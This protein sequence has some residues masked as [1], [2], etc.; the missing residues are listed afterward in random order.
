MQIQQDPIMTICFR[1]YEKLVKTTFRCIFAL[2]PQEE[3]PEKFGKKLTDFGQIFRT[4]SPE[5]EKILICDH[6]GQLSELHFDLSCTITPEISFIY[7]QSFSLWP[8]P[9]IEFKKGQNQF[10]NRSPKNLVYKTLFIKELTHTL[11]ISKHDVIGIHEKKK[12]F[13]FIPSHFC[14][15]LESLRDYNTAFTL[16]AASLMLGV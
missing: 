9:F 11:F 2:P 8:S 16:L 1:V 3:G 7:D 6:Y 5:L 13:P 4:F 15:L 12:I 10:Y 14:K